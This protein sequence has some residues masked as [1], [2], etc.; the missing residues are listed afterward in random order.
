MIT[1]SK[2][3]SKQRKTRIFSASKIAL[4]LHPTSYQIILP[5][6]P[7]VPCS[8]YAY[9]STTVLYLSCPCPPPFFLP[10]F[11]ISLAAKLTSIR[12]YY[13]HSSLFTMCG[14]LGRFVVGD[15]EC[16][17]LTFRPNLSSSSSSFF[18]CLVDIFFCF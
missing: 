13:L 14:R 5:V 6:H 4:P 1:S 17:S 18:L 8:R 12:V 15:N 7:S 10:P 9:T 16:S 2:Q 3:A 11:F